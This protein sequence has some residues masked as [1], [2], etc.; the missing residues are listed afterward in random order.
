MDGTSREKSWGGGGTTNQE[1]LGE[2]HVKSFGDLTHFP[3]ARLLGLKTDSHFGILRLK[4]QTSE[5]TGGGGEV[6]K[7]LEGVER[8][9]GKRGELLPLKR[10]F[11]IYY[12][13]AIVTII[14]IIF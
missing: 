7:G 5:R 2:L 4:A 14:I 10:C 6:T 13:N 8:R 9:R 3:P 12:L 11:L 1:G